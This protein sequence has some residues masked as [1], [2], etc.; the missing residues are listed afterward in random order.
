M[1]NISSIKRVAFKSR[2][3]DTHAH[4]GNWEHKNY[5]V[6]CLDIFTDSKLKNGDI[7]EKILISNLDCIGRENVADEFNGNSRLLTLIKGNSKYAPYAVCQPNITRGNISLIKKLFV[8]NPNSFIGLKF[9]PK[10]MCLSANNV[11][12]D[13]YL[14]FAH[15][16]NLPC[17]FHS[18]KSYDV[19]YGFGNIDRRCEY[20]QP[21]QIYELAK[22]HKKVPVI[23]GHM[24]GNTGK[25][26][27]SA[28]D[29]IIDS[30]ENSTANLYADISW[31]NADN[32]EK[33]DII[34]AIKR[35]KNTSKGDRTDRLL[36][37]SDAP[38]GRFGKNTNNL[39]PLE[40]YQKVVDD[41]KNAIKRNFSQNEA[42]EIIEKIFYKNAND[43]FFSKKQ[44]NLKKIPL[45]ITFLLL[46]MGVIFGLVINKKQNNFSVPHL[47]LNNSQDN[48][49]FQKSD[50]FKTFNMLS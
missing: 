27:E 2:I 50:V 33:S 49:S 13:N 37:G 31:V 4:I 21:E 19:D 22:R 26:C 11:A 28:I 16:Y 20:S 44:T 24:G 36:F 14:K 8:E 17:L 42:E 23:L 40:S 48:F 12:Y 30:I 10:E 43:L 41:V 39:T 6:F 7:V 38:L 46:T 29:I 47:P 3:I 25:N 32:S 1:T 34:Y 45:Y 9:H 18:D 5:G 15:K 35:L